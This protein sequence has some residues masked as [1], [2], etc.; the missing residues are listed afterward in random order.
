MESFLTLGAIARDV[1]DFVEQGVH[2]KVDRLR[3]PT[4]G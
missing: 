1:D 4:G 2:E 3:A